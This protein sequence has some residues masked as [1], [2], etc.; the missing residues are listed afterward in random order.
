MTADQIAFLDLTAQAIMDWRARRAPL[1]LKPSEYR[2]FCIELHRV[3]DREGITE[4]DVRLKGSAAAFFSAPHKVFPETADRCVE[5]AQKKKTGRTPAAVRAAYERFMAGAA[6]TL[7]RPPFDSMFKLGVASDRSD[8]DIQMSSGQIARRC[9]EARDAATADERA[10]WELVRA[11]FG[12]FEDIWFDLACPLVASWSDDWSGR[13][14]RTVTVKA[15][16]HSGPLDKSSEIGLLSS[17]FR[18]IDWMLS[19][20]TVMD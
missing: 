2:A 3:I 10:R 8:Y 14:G 12:F 15:F 20:A 18:D 6:D 13:L 4:L 9:R 16:D 19:Q 5:L 17:H 1:G 11:G 7:K